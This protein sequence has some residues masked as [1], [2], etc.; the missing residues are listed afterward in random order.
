VIEPEELIRQ[1]KVADASVLVTL[2]TW[3]GLAKQIQEGTGIPQHGIDRPRGLSFPAEVLISRWRNRGLNVERALR[4]NRWLAQ[5]TTKSPA[6]DVLPEDLAVILFTGGTTAQSKGC[7]AFASQSG[8]ECLA[9]PSLAAQCG[10]RQGKVFVRCA[11]LP[12]L[13]Y[14]RCDERAGLHRC[15]DDPQTAVPGVGCFEDHQE[16]QADHLPRFAEHVRCHQ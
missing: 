4:W 8:G 5:Q 9:D 7:D 3:A 16:I 13:R 12:Q 10:G 11:I 6:V 2:S 14:D 1:V 15:G